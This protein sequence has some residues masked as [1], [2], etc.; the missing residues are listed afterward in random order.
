[1]KQTLLLLLGPTGAG[2]STIVRHLESLDVRFRYIRPYTTRPLRDGESDKVF[3][4]ESDMEHLWRDGGLLVV[5]TLY[6]IKY[7]TP[8]FPIEEAFKLGLF[9][10]IDWPI[11]QIEIMNKAY[12]GLLL[13]VYVKPPDLETLKKRLSE[14]NDFDVRVE[15]AQQELASLEKDHYRENIDLIVSNESG[16]SGETALKIYKQYIAHCTHS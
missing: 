9:P 2:K 1:V 8:R 3:V 6:G 10:V 7:G 15:V 11:Q 16:L 12:P 14:R 5:N 4:T 13:R